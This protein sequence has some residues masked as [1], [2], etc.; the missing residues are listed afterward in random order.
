V[1]LFFFF[2]YLLFNTIQIFSLWQ[3]SNIVQLIDKLRRQLDAKGIV[4]RQFAQQRRQAT[5]ST[6][7]SIVCDI[8]GSVLNEISS[9][10]RVLAQRVVTTPFEKINL[11]SKIN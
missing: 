8:V 2:F 7:Q 1:F 10:N 11:K 3:H 9:Q 4:R 5:N 6:A